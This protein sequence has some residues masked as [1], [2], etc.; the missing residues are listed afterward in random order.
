MMNADGTDVNL[1]DLRDK[2]YVIDPAWS[3]NGQLLAF[4]WRRP[5]G[6]YDLYVMDPT[7]RTSSTSPPT[8]AAATSAQLGSRR[9]LHRFDLRAT[10]PAKSGLHARRRLPASPAHHRT[11]TTSRP[12]GR[13][14]KTATA[15]IYQKPARFTQ[16]RYAQV[17]IFSLNDRFYCSFLRFLSH[18]SVYDE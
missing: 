5:D 1:L 2:G 13:R 6:N 9:P 16:H 17:P 8:P 15:Q 10:V 3:P 7:S 18:L 12:T 4:S 11:A 14:S